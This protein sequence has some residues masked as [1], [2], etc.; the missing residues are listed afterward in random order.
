M[1]RKL[2]WRWR[3]RCAFWRFGDGIRYAFHLGTIGAT[4]TC[5]ACER[6]VD[7]EI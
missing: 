6:D 5:P 4:V 3:L 2:G 1:K 7:I